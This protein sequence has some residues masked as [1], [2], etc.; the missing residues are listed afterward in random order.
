MASLGVADAAH[1]STRTLCV[2]NKPLRILVAGTAVA[3]VI[4]TA[5]QAL[6][7]HQK[8]VVASL[9]QECQ[10]ENKRAQEHP[11]DCPSWENAPL[12]CEP[13]ELTS[14]GAA[15]G[16]QAQIVSEQSQIA[17]FSSWS[18][19]AAALTF[20]LSVTPAA[21]HFLLARIKELREAIAG[22]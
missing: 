10:T 21:W 9:V 15:V 16:L 19:I 13:N 1:R 18:R 4:F 12:L 11:S 14:T 7:K 5:G 17:V 6:M 20:I 8:A 22:K 3:A 2:M